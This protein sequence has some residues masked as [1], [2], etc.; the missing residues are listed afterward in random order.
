MKYNP[1]ETMQKFISPISSS[2][3]ASEMLL[4]Y[5]R[6][7]CCRYYST[8]PYETNPWRASTDALVSS[9]KIEILPT[10]MKMHLYVRKNAFDI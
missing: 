7:L 9:N 10:V 3:D 6:S 2:L 4:R 5:Y 8:S 1:Q